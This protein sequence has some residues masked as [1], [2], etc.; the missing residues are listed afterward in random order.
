[1]KAL[2]AYANGTYV[3]GW[4]T[5]PCLGCSNFKSLCCVSHLRPHE[6]AHVPLRQ[7]PSAASAQTA[8]TLLA[9]RKFY[10][11]SARPRSNSKTRSTVYK[12]KRKNATGPFR[13]P[14]RSLKLIELAAGNLAQGVINQVKAFSRYNRLRGC[15]L[16]ETTTYFITLYLETFSLKSC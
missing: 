14:T 16:G 4:Q 11:P 9:T 8:L 13:S 1:M 6:R 2:V 10:F 15:K 7:H 3:T 5:R 12:R